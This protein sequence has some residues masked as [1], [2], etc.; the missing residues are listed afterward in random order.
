MNIG[1]IL[2]WCCV[3]ISLHAFYL[4]AFRTYKTKGNEKKEERV[5]LPNIFY[6]LIFASVFVPI[7]NIIV[8]GIF[9]IA[10]LIDD[11]DNFVVDSWLFKKPGQK[12][13]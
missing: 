1:V 8:S 9:Y 11:K 2:Y 3:L 7:L 4:L 5:L 10:T 6:V 12:S 13:E